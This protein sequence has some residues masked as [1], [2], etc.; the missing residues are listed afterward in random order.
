MAT[1]N[2][3]PMRQSAV[4][5]GWVASQSLVGTNGKRYPDPSYIGALVEQ[6]QNTLAQC[7]DNWIKTYAKGA[8]KTPGNDFA[9][10][11]D[12]LGDSRVAQRLISKVKELLAEQL[13]NLVYSVNIDA[14]RTDGS[15]SDITR[16]QRTQVREAAA[17]VA[18]IEEVPEISSGMIRNA[19]YEKIRISLY[20]WEQNEGQGRRPAPAAAPAPQPVAEEAEEAVAEGESDEIPF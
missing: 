11:V 8:R 15:V 18:A 17:L 10:V 13:V 19:A 5:P 14:N 20:F 12:D 2:V 3:V 1:P 16:E 6:I 7:R 4:V 9:K